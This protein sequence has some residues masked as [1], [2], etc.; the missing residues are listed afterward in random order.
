MDLTMRP[1]FDSQERLKVF[2]SLLG[3]TQPPFQ[4]VPLVLS[5]GLKRPKR[6]A[7]YSLHLVS[8]L[9]IHKALTMI[10]YKTSWRSA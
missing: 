6:K 2:Y 4:W 10:S 1:S 5:L 8:K 3:P 9:R 7:E